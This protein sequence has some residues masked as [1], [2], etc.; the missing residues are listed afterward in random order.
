MEVVSLVFFLSLLALW[1]TA[2]AGSSS[3]PVRVG[4][5]LDLGSDVGRE[6]LACVSEALHDF[7]RKHRPS[8]ATPVVE[9]LVRD[10]LGDLA[11]S[12][13]AGTSYVALHGPI[14]M[15]AWPSNVSVNFSFRTPRGSRSPRPALVRAP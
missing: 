15:T 9:L 7:E 4:V 8:Y 11:T 14:Y 3:S 1:S 2:A 10:S 13:H 12:M 5:V 6:R